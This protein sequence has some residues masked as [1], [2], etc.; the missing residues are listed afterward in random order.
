MSVSKSTDE[1]LAELDFALAA[2]KQSRAVF[3]GLTK[4]QVDELLKEL[5][6]SSSRL[7][8]AAMQSAIL[9]QIEEKGM[10]SS[11]SGQQ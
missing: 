1:L 9:K 11:T 8:C 7:A 3:E 2:Q 10:K 4:E 6:P 5:L